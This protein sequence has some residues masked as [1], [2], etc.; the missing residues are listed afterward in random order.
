MYYYDWE[1]MIP[2]SFFSSV[3]WFQS[4][5]FVENKVNGGV[6]TSDKLE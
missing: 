6:L 5:I 3:D 2:N 4:Q 1:S